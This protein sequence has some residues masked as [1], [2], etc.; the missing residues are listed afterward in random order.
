MLDD[1]IINF[2]TDI[3]KKYYHLVSSNCRRRLIDTN[4]LE[5]AIQSTFLMYI[6]EEKKISSSLSSWFYWTSI[7]VCKAINR[8]EKTHK[9][10][11]KKKSQ[12]TPFNLVNNDTLDTSDL[13]AQLKNMID[14]LPQ[15][16]Q[17]MLLMRFYDDMTYDQ[18]AFH[19][20][21][22]G[23]SVRKMIDH[24]LKKIRYEI[25]KKDIAFSALF[26]QFFDKS[27]CLNNSLNHLSN[28]N[29]HF[30]I[31][32]SITQQIIVKSVEQMLLFLKFKK[33]MV[34]FLLI[35]LPI[36]TVVLA[37][38]YLNSS[39]EKD[40]TNEKNTYEARQDISE[41]NKLLNEKKEGGEKNN[42]SKNAIVIT[43]D[44]IGKWTLTKKSEEFPCEVGSILIV[45]KDGT[46]LV[47]GATFK[48]KGKYTLINN[49]FTFYFSNKSVYA[50]ECELNHNSVRF[51]L[52]NG[53]KVFWWMEYS[54]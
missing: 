36:S 11:N 20:K 30:I 43:S 45:N 22:N 1:K 4:S 12:N 37:N 29:S 8:R 39:N 44:L 52:K 5:D 10:F 18:I 15:K 32:N 46:F 41:K 9:E 23:D 14:K 47:N 25:S 49:I 21:S 34:V 50:H 26:A 7:N 2:E 19:F 27:S 35:S 51:V 48:E 3:Y 17:E 54:K 28:S 38:S 53:N 40:T 42:V 16:K 24:T 6:R 33:A 31:Q 13:Q